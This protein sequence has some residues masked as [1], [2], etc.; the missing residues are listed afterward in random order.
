MCLNCIANDIT[1]KRET[2]YDFG[3]APL[4]CVK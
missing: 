2:D 4:T 3:T 1:T